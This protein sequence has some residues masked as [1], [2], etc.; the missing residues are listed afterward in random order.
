MRDYFLF[1]TR[2]RRNKSN[3]NNVHEFKEELKD[4]EYYNQKN[5]Y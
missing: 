4:N 5:H 1:V 3:N 2:S